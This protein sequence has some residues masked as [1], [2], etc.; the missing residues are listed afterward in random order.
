MTLV[1]FCRTC[2]G[3]RR[4]RRLAAVRTAA[5][6]VIMPQPMATSESMLCSHCFDRAVGISQNVVGRV[7][8]I[9][10]RHENAGCGKLYWAVASAPSAPARAEPG[11][12]RQVHLRG[13]CAIWAHQQYK[14]SPFLNTSSVLNLVMGRIQMSMRVSKGGLQQWLATMSET[15]ASRSRVRT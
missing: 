8:A 12:A 10:L 4:R 15:V 6:I 11:K 2:G 7:L 5:S 3:A 1:T 13:A 9:E 14:P